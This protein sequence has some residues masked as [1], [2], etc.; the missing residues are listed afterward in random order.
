MRKIAILFLITAHGYGLYKGLINDEWIY[1]IACM[2]GT[3]LGDIA[4]RIK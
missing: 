2:T 1:L 3:I 4:A